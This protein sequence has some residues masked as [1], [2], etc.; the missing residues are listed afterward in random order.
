MF[1]IDYW[2]IVF[3]IPPTLLA[4]WASYNVK[5]TFKKYQRVMNRYG[6]SGSEAARR[7]LD[8]NGL[9]HVRIERVSGNLTDHYDPRTNVIRLSD[10]VYDSHSVAAVGVA[11]H[12]AGHAVQYAKNYSPIKVRASILPIANI[13]SSLGFILAFVGIVM[14]Y[15]P[16]SY[17]GIALFSCVVLFQLITLPVEFNA[18]HRAVEI[19]SNGYFSEDELDGTKKVLRAAALTYVASLLVAIGNLL[20]LIM[21]VNSRSRD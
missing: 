3:V 4:L 7:I 2:Y 21:I 10:S 19:L 8:A 17:I 18:S 9:G 15:P 14:S 20:R 12:E 1:W 16:V 13:G 5:S 6:M 11:A